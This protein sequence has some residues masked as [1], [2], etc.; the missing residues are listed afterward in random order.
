MVGR[1][2]GSLIKTK[3]RLTDHPTDVRAGRGRRSISP[4]CVSGPCPTL[5]MY[6][7]RP[8]EMRLSEEELASNTQGCLPPP[9]CWPLLTPFS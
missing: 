4:V 7:S 5:L 3:T 1:L 9:V 2:T 6:Y 8:N